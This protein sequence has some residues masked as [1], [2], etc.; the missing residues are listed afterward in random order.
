[1]QIEEIKVDFG[2]YLAH[3]D[4]EFEVMAQKKQK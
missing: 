1:M 3:Q 2:F 4:S